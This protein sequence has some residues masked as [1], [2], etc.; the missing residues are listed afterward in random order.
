MLIALVLMVVPLI[1]FVFMKSRQK[2]TAFPKDSLGRASI[3]LDIAFL[4]FFIPIAVLT[5]SETDSESA[6]N[7]ALAAALT[8]IP[9]AAC[10]TGMISMIKSKERCILVFA[11]TTLGLGLLLGAIGYWFI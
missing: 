11:S 6:M 3:V 9:L 8:V 4:L 2:V 5:H 1:L 10:I 7:P